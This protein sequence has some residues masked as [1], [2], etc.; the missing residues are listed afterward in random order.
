M[1][2]ANLSK[3]GVPIPKAIL[4]LLNKSPNLRK[5]IKMN[6]VSMSYK[7]NKQAIVSTD[8]QAI[9]N[10]GFKQFNVKSGT[11]KAEKQM[12]KSMKKIINQV[13]EKWNQQ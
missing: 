3:I 2:G 4:R 8:N 12:I 10:L 5:H 9:N 11:R 1:F 13:Q 6:D 7:V